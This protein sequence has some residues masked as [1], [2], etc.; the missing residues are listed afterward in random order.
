MKNIFY[1]FVLLLML[2]S[3]S[4]QFPT[5][6]YTMSKGKLDVPK[7]ESYLVVYQASFS[8][9]LKA[10]VA[11]SNESGK[12]TELKEVSGAWE[13]SVTLKS[14]T[15]VQLKTF[16]TAER[17]SKGEYKIL[18]DGKVVSEYILSGRK[19]KY[20]FAFDLP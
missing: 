1:C 17:K 16:A 2:S 4:I 13:K 14:G 5:V 9:G 6:L 7:K 12:E 3:C 15:H 20:S 10:D 11:Y 8:D 18:V 19:L